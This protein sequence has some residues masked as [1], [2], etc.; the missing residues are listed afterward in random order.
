MC[1]L[2][3]AGIDN[4][5]SE[6]DLDAG[7]KFDVVIDNSGNDEALSVQLQDLLHSI[8]SKLNDD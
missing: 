2:I 5:E 8:N 4:A 3:F 1:G 7:V 6:C